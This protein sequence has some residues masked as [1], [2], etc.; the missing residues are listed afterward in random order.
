MN[1]D[2]D[3]D[4][5]ESDDAEDDGDDD[6]DV[7]GGYWEEVEGKAPTAIPPAPLSASSS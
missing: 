6:D 4:D 2:E 3:G 7:G 1:D 5:A